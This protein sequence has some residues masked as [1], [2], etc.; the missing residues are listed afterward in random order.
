MARA[1][2]IAGA[3]RGRAARRG[4]G[5]AAPATCVVETRFS[6]I[7]RGTEALVF[8]GGVPRG[9]AGADACAAA[10]GRLPVPGEVRLRGGRR[11]RRR[12][13]RRS[14][15]RDVFVLH[16]HQDRFAAPAAMAVP[17]P[18]GVPP[19]RAV[20]AANMETAL[21]VVWDARRGRPA[22]AS[23]W[24]APG[25]VGALAGWLC[26]RLPGAEVTL[27]DLNPG[28]AALAAALGCRLRAAGGGAG[29]LRPRHPRQRHRRGARDRA[30]RGRAARR[31]W[32]R[33]AGTATG[34][35]RV[36]LGG[37]FHSRRLRLVSSQV[38][39]VP[40][41]A[42]RALE[43]PAPARGGARAARRPGARRADQR[44]D[45]LRRPAR[46]ATARSSSAPGHALPSH[47]LLRRA[48]PCTPSR[49]ATT[50]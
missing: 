49:S 17:L 46:R 10:G 29:R 7:S 33:R 25:V 30:G 43:Q 18:D 5:A 45:R 21:N 34:R 2:W 3:G 26:A 32:S 39:L 44:R 42:A 19:G 23:R 36:G 6:G 48:P 14:L 8:R 28:R 20:L 27:V 15:G 37:A 11:G 47:P 41:G 22:T 38:G 16:P 12:A 9:R 40:T 24:S 1:L 31:P 4:G 13:A 50:S 35:R